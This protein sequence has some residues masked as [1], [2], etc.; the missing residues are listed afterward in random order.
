M[1]ANNPDTFVTSSTEESDARKLKREAMRALDRDIDDKVQYWIDS[2]VHSFSHDSQSN[3]ECPVIFVVATFDD[4]FESEEAQRRCATLQKRLEKNLA[5]KI[6]SVPNFKAPILYPKKGYKTCRVSCGPQKSGT[7]KVEEY[8]HYLTQTHVIQGHLKYLVTARSANSHFVAHVEDASVAMIGEKDNDY[9]KDVNSV[10]GTGIC[11]TSAHITSWKSVMT[12]LTRVGLIHYF[13]GS[14]NALEN[15]A[16]T[17]HKFLIQIFGSLL[18]NENTLLNHEPQDEEKSENQNEEELHLRRFLQQCIVSH[19]IPVLTDTEL[20]MLWKGCKE[21][22][23]YFSSTYSAKTTLDFTK[24]LLLKSGTLVPLYSPGNCEKTIYLLPGL[25]ENNCSAENC[26]FSYKCSESWKTSLCMTWLFSDFVPSNI[27]EDINAEILK[28]IIPLLWTKSVGQS[29]TDGKLDEGWSGLNIRDISCT[30]SSLSLKLGLM[31]PTGCNMSSEKCETLV[32]L[33]VHL[34]EKKSP[35][36]VASASML[37][38]KRR[39]IVCAK[40]PAGSDGK[41]VWSGGFQQIIDIIDR[42]LESQEEAFALKFE[43]E[44]VCPDCIL[45]HDHVSQASVWKWNQILE[46]SKRQQEEMRCRRN[47]HPVRVS[48]LNNE[49]QPGSH[50]IASSNCGP[51]TVSSSDQSNS[52]SRLRQSYHE[53]SPS[54][55]SSA[56]PASKL[57]HGVVLVGLLDKK[58]GLIVQ[59]GSGFIVD[60]EAGLIITA[61]HTFINM[62]N[63]TNDGKSNPKFGEW[64]CGL[65]DV[66][67]VVGVIPSALPSSSCSFSSTTTSSSSSHQQTAHSNSQNPETMMRNNTAVFRYF[68]KIVTADVCNVDAC[69]LW[70]TKKIEVDLKMENDNAY[71]DIGAL[72]N[73]ENDTKNS[74]VTDLRDVSCDFYKE[75]GL[76]Q[77]SITSACEYQECVRV[78][79]YNQGGEGLFAQGTHVNRTV[80]LSIGY[81]SKKFECPKDSMPPLTAQKKSGQ[82]DDNIQDF[83]QPRKE[84]IVVGCQTIGGHSGGPCVNEGGEVIGILSRADPSEA[85]RCYIAPT[86]E[87]VNLIRMA[88]SRREYYR[89]R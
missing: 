30:K 17:N 89:R 76:T 84:I 87:W 86:G 51:C 23:R 67:I 20:L 83:F 49:I 55:R 40:G 41:F 24:E 61:S 15:L 31:L 44:I 57:L 68:A 65:E 50:G 77:L 12:Y 29:D 11:S 5:A 85:Q 58:T 38:G 34:A 32:E 39:L 6:R 78:L 45:S 46:A 47:A 69:V 79:G 64:Y 59:A 25:L 37:V 2:T 82:D 81:V 62:N 60:V 8:I 27:M 88:R 22:E 33:F 10:M 63:F 66:E 19:K 73:S 71:I 74:N 16:V 3:V 4:K 13:G 43:K 72:Y 53:I 70:I 75:E 42:F 52:V 35:L 1:G 14:S 7:H 26:Y 54:V 80:D 36:C 21:L 9:L 28:K 56:V 48:L 18:L